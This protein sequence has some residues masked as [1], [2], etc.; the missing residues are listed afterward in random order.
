MESQIARKVFTNPLYFFAFGFGSGLS[1]IA[2]GTLG[3]LVGIL[4]YLLMH[5]LPLFWYMFITLGLTLLAI[6]V[7]SIV[8][9]EIGVHDYTGINVDEIV[10]FLWTMTAIPFKWYWILLGFLLFRLFDI[11]K[12][13]PIRRLDQTVL[14]G[15]GMVLD[16]LVAALYSWILLAII[17]FLRT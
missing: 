8:S 11:W 5:F 12:P 17:I 14:G 7:S 9:K 4:I 15:W 13:W 16:D 2:P 6:R 3:T 10:G 1:P